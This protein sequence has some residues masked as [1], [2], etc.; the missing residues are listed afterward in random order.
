MILL[1]SHAVCCETLQKGAKNTSRRR[2][3]FSFL[4]VEQHSK[5][6]NVVERRECC[7]CA[8]CSIRNDEIASTKLVGLLVTD[9]SHRVHHLCRACERTFLHTVQFWYYYYLKLK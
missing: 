3:F 6:K 8:D 4:T 2:A 7:C 1:F 9:M 5:C